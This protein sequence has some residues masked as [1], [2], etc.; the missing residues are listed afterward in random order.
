MKRGKKVHW[1]AEGLEHS[2]CG[3]ST[4]YYHGVSVDEFGNLEKKERCLRCNNSYME[5]ARGFLYADKIYKHQKW[6][7]HKHLKGQGLVGATILLNRLVLSCTYA[8]NYS[9]PYQNMKVKYID[10]NDDFS[11]VKRSSKFTN[12]ICLNSGS[13]YRNNEVLKSP[14]QL[15]NIKRLIRLL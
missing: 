15:K 8:I 13:I 14:K 10:F 7:G 2:P 9:E 5:H 11:Y 4:T 3:I 12:D 1:S 6:L